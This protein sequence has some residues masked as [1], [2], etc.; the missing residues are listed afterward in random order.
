MRTGPTYLSDPRCRSRAS[1]GICNI[2]VNTC[3]SEFTVTK[4]NPLLLDIT[5][6]HIRRQLPVEGGRISDI[7]EERAAW[8]TLVRH[9]ARERAGAR[10]TTIP[11]DNCR[12]TPRP[13][14]RQGRPWNPVT[15]HSHFL[16]PPLAP[17]L[18]VTRRGSLLSSA[19]FACWFSVAFGESRLR[20]WPW[21]WFCC[22]ASL[23]RTGQSGPRRN[24]G[25]FRGSLGQR[26]HGDLTLS[27][28]STTCSSGGQQERMTPD[29]GWIGG[30]ALGRR[31]ERMR[32]S[33]FCLYA[34]S[35]WV[36]VVTVF[37]T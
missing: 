3:H 36:I 10:L 9:H 12:W 6:A 33:E 1:F 18:R 35:G 17:R 16:G 21:W 31:G 24:G 28:L 29:I 7:A 8:T 20:R 30:V 5:R 19:P 34:R 11:Q 15:R 37:V 27:L 22:S 4:V 26:E 25:S 2:Q 13:T 32:I 23:W 14:R